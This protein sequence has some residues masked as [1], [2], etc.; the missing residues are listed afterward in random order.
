MEE[1]LLDKIQVGE[2]C[3]Q[4]AWEHVGLLD[5]LETG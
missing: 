3:A 5:L 4:G 1:V 2:I